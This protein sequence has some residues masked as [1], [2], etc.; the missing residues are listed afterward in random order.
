MSF[1]NVVLCIVVCVCDWVSMESFRRGLILFSFLVLVN[2]KLEV[3]GFWNNFVRL[4]FYILRNVYDI[5]KVFF[6]IGNNYEEMFFFEKICE[7]CI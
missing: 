1:W 5:F 2:W 7:I 3:N 6:V 4:E